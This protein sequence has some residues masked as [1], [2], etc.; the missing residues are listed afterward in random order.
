MKV[1]EYYTT[2][3]LTLAALEELEIHQIHEQSEK[4]NKPTSSFNFFFLFVSCFF[5]T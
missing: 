3:S 1:Q 5:L 2:P 4:M